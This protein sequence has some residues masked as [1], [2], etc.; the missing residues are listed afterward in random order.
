MKRRLTT[1]EF[2]KK[3]TKIHKGF[4]TYTKVKYLNAHKKVIITCPTH[5]DFLQSPHNHTHNEQGCMQCGTIITRKSR[6]NTLDDFL[7]KARTLHK[8]KYD[9][10]KVNYEKCD[11]K[12]CII[13]K[14]HGEFYQMPESHLVGNGCPK[15]VSKISN[16]EIDFL[17]Y[18]QIPD[19]TSHRQKYI[20]PYKVD[21]INKNIIYEFLG[22]TG[23]AIPQNFHQKIQ[24]N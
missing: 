7:Q 1:K 9:Y 19:D 22:I 23:T 18:C 21:A 24:M 5:G 15:C 17:N 10:S 16:P 12:I 3:A 20:K 6:L 4:Y 2:I 11:I 14:S 13:C 8:N